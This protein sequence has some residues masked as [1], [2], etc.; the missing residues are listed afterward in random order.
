VLDP[1]A[2]WPQVSFVEIFDRATLDRSL[3][4]RPDAELERAWEDRL[5][6]LTLQVLKQGIYAP[7]WRDHLD[8]GTQ[9][10]L[11]TER[12]VEVMLNEAFLEHETRGDPAYLVTLGT[13]DSRPD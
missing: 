13:D 7:G 8:R 9:R 6:L 2:P 12:Q 5:S 3:R 4:E 1:T 10:R 11:F